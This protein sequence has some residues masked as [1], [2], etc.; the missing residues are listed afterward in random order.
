MSMHFRNILS[1]GFLALLLP[2]ATAQQNIRISEGLKM[3]ADVIEL[4][5]ELGTLG[6]IRKFSFSDYAIA[7]DKRVVGTARHRQNFTGTK[8]ESTSTRT[9]SF[10][11]SNSYSDSVDVRMMHN[12]IL[13]T[14]DRKVFGIIRVGENELQDSDYFT[15][16]IAIRGDTNTW[17]LFIEQ[18][19]GLSVENKEQAFMTNGTR[20]ITIEL[21]I[22]KNTGFSP[23]GL[24]A[25]GYEFVEAGQSIAAL[26]YF[27]G[28]FR[29]TADTVWM[30]RRLDDKEKLRLAAAMIA[31]V[32]RVNEKNL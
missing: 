30:D 29:H 27:T 26:E 23:L 5:L 1:L 3:H 7:G 12:T 15:A 22:E 14:E 25:V 24:P 32:H 2:L 16:F 18:T 11:L 9:F 31:I 20:Y 21:L 8:S 6:R 17:T 13:S 4:Q 19:S 28:D 10:V